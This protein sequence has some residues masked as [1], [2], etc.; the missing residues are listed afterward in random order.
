MTSK[1]TDLLHLR[2]IR[3]GFDDDEEA[4]AAFVANV[5][6]QTEGNETALCGNQAS[7][8]PCVTLMLTTKFKQE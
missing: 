2:S 7:Y 5:F 1:I 6:C 8:M 3:N 4:K